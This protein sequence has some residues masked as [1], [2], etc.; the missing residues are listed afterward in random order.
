[1][2]TMNDVLQKVYGRIRDN[3]DLTIDF[4][5]EI[6]EGNERVRVPIPESLEEYMHELSISLEKQKNKNNV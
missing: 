3:A 2:S 1:M 4:L 6:N 5:K